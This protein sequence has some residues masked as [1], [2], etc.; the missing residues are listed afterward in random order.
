MRISQNGIVLIKKFEGCVLTAYKDIAGVLTIGYGHTGSDVTQGLHISQTRANELLRQDLT[1][2]ETGVN[3]CVKV[4]L[5]QNQFDALVSFS[6]NVGMS[7]LRKS[8]LLKKLNG[9]DYT[10]A[11][12]EFD[13]WVHAG[14]KVVRGLQNRR[15]AEQLLFL[16]PVKQPTTPQGTFYYTVLKGDNLTKIAKRYN[17][18]VNNLVKLN[19]IPDPNRIFEGQRLRIN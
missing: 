4:P 14:G 13:R 15:D 10:G 18:T 5:N 11:A 19:N 16:T 3:D 8:T 17:T 2:F 1:N 9:K 6:F 12:N 7:A